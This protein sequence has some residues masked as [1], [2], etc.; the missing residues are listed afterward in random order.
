MH[1]YAVDAREVR[2]APVAQ[3]ADLDYRKLSAQGPGDGG[4]F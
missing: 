2:V 4:R 1:P 3:K